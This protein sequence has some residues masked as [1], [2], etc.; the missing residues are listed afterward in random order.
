MACRN[1]AL[2]WREACDADGLEGLGLYQLHGVIVGL[3]FTGGH[4]R[5]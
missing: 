3:A 2:Q 5:V 1:V 4:R